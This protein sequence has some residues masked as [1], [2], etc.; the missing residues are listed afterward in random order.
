M[1]KIDHASIDAYSYYEN[2]IPNI[3]VANRYD[4]IDS[5]AFNVLHELC[6]VVNHLGGDMEQNISLNDYDNDSLQEREANKYATSTLIPDEI[7]ELAPTVPMN[8]YVIQ[9]IYTRWAKLI[10]VNK[11]IVLGRI[12]YETGIYRF[13]DDGTRSI[14]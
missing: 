4:H 14:K 9:N 6:H 7:W 3:I 12:S 11:W 10:Q 5:L 8:S 13:K 2:G 1:S